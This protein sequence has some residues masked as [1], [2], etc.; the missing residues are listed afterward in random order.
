MSEPSCPRCDVALVRIDVP[1]APTA[2]AC[3][4]GAR[5]ALDAAT[6][7]AADVL[8]ELLGEVVDAL[9]SVLG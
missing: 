6:S 7:G 2:R 3:A 9:A 4:C 1:N 8:G 5:T